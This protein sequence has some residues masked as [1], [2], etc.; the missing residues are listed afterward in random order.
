MRN[1]N[2]KK[3]VSLLLLSLVVSVTIVRCTS[4]KRFKVLSFIFDGVP[5]PSKKATNDS[6]ALSNSTSS[7]DT[8][9]KNISNTVIP[10]SYMHKPYEEHKCTSCHSGEF[11]NELIK[12][13]PDLC[14][15]CHEDFS[16]KY[17]LLH[18]PVASGY[19]TACHNQHEGKFPKMLMLSGQ[20]LCLNC[21]ESKQVFKNKKHENI[22][23]K[24]CTECHNPHGGESRAFLKSGT[25][26]SCHE[27]FSTKY[28]FVHGPVV[29]GNCTA[30][31]DSHSSKQ[32]KLLL[33][34]AQQLCLY[35]HS[36]EPLYKNKAH[37]EARNKNCT[38]CHNPHGGEDRFILVDAIRPNKTKPAIQTSADSLSKSKQLSTIAKESPSKKEAVKTA[39]KTSEKSDEKLIIKNT[40]TLIELKTED[41][42]NKYVISSYNSLQDASKR[43]EEML[44]KGYKDVVIVA[45]E[46]DQK[47]PL[48]KV[49]NDLQ[50]LYP[51]AKTDDKNTEK[52]NKSKETS[53]KNPYTFRVQV[54]DIK[55]ETSSDSTQKI[56]IIP[57]N[58]SGKDSVNT[59]SIVP[60]E[61]K[62]K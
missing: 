49:P 60:Q 32:P 20:D 36:E 11:S 18:G 34:E 16:T 35:C 14:Y 58:K 22:G 43:K 13:V 56:I 7:S 61:N 21:H 40:D 51:Y 3:I 57:E 26:Y 28:N 10:E 31:H 29:S 44:K 55:E 27:N 41:G 25:C 2:K 33:R 1:A 38:E 5:D 30:C 19:C 6:I 54:G 39:N 62:P 24:N 23:S 59:N 46:N 53:G 12:P 47:I 48:S 52:K 17:Q 45:F 15:T 4:E 8:L 50:V 9:K 37:K 42:L